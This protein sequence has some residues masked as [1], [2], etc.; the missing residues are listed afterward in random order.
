MPVLFTSHGNPMD[1]PLSKEEQPFWDT[2]SHLGKELQ[3]KY[4]VKAALIGS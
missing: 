1:I 2:L 3:S 4:E